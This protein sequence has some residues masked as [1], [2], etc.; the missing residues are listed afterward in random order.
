MHQLQLR[1]VEKVGC[2][3]D[4]FCLLINIYIYLY[5]YIYIYI[6]IDNRINWLYFNSNRCYPITERIWKSQDDDLQFMKIY[7]YKL[8]Q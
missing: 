1:I 3:L 7:E 8:F 5:I 6:Y 4:N 2:K